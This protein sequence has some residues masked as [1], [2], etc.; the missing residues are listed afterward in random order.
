MNDVDGGFDLFQCVDCVR[1]AECWGEAGVSKGVQL[2]NDQC[3]DAT[4]RREW[5]GGE[6][7]AQGNRAN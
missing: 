5:A 3:I 6:R 7:K 1:K 4:V 2:T